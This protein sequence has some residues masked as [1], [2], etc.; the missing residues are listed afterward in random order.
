MFLL[1]IVTSEIDDVSANNNVVPPIICDVSNMPDNSHQKILPTVSAAIATDTTYNISA[2]FVEN[3]DYSTTAT[4]EIS[5]GNT[6]GVNVNAFRQSCMSAPTTGWDN[7]I[8]NGPV[9]CYAMES[10]ISAYHGLQGY[11]WNI[12][13]QVYIDSNYEY[14]RSKWKDYLQKVRCIV[15]D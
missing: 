4:A 5:A 13:F 12:N 2:N 7:Y 15:P 3:S 1:F 11:N 14:W 8:K 9:V 6:Y 10:L